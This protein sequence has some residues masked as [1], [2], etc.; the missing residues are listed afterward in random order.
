MITA[1]TV[2]KSRQKK[3]YIDVFR[4]KKNPSFMELYSVWIPTSSLSDSGR[5]NGALTFSKCDDEDGYP[6][7]E[8]TS[9]WKPCCISTISQ[10]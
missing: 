7:A 4:E 9:Q 6:E 5:S 3:C 2:M 1:K 10:V 8:S